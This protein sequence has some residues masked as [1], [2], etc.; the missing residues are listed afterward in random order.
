MSFQ[1]SGPTTLGSIKNNLLVK[2]TSTAHP[3]GVAMTENQWFRK[4]KAE[5]ESFE[6]KSC[7]LFKLQIEKKYITIQKGNARAIRK[8][9]TAL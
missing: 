3:Y 1:V 4:T 6:G 7:F 8:H 2:S 5:S 9:R